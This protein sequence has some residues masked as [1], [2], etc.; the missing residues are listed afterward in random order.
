[1]AYSI[2]EVDGC[3]P[4]QNRF[5]VDIMSSP[6]ELA[7]PE[8]TGQLVDA[9]IPA[10]IMRDDEHQSDPHTMIIDGRD[11]SVDGSKLDTI[12]FNAEVNNLTDQQANSLTSGTHSAWHHHD[13][14]YYRK[15]DLFLPGMSQVNWG[16]LINVPTEFPCAPHDHNDIYYTETEIDNFLA[17]IS[18]SSHDHDDRYYTETEIDTIL[19]NYSLTTHIHDDRYFTETEIET[20]YYDMPEIDALLAGI[21]TQGIKGSVDQHRDLPASGNEEGDI[22]IVRERNGI[23]EPPSYTGA[24]VQNADTALYMKLENTIDDEMGHPN[25]YSGTG[26]VYQA[27]RNGQSGDLNDGFITFTN[28]P[29]FQIVNNFTAGCWLKPNRYDEVMSIFDHWGN[30]SSANGW[31][32]L[33]RDGKIEV[34]LKSTSVPQITVVSYSRIKLDEWTHVAMTYDGTAI[35]LWKN[36]IVV[37]QGIFMG[38]IDNIPNV[39][40]IGRYWTDRIDGEIDELFLE[41][42]TY[43]ELQMQQL[44]NGGLF[45]GYRDE[46]FYRW[47]GSDWIW[48]DFNNGGIYHNSLL[49]LNAEDYRHLDRNEKSDLVDGHDASTRH[50]HGSLYYTQTYVDSNFYTSTQLDGGQLDNRYFTE[51]EIISNYYSSAQLNGGQL[52]NLYYTETEVDN[53]LANK[54]D[55]GHM[56]D[57]RYYTEVEMDITLANYSLI[58]HTHDDRYYQEVEVDNL[59]AGK[60]DVGHIH[61]DRYYTETELSSSSGVSGASLI[62]VSL[63]GGITA[64]NVQDALQELNDDITTAIFTLQEAYESNQTIT[65]NSGPLVLNATSSTDAPMQI[66]N[67]TAAPTS[68]LAGGQMAIINNEFYTFNVDKNKWLTPSKMVFFGKNGSADGHVLRAPGGVRHEESGYKMPKKGTIIAASL[69]ST[70]TTANK[71]VY[72]RINTTNVFTLT[73][74]ASGDDIATT[75]NTDFNIGDVLSAKISSVGNPISNVTVTL[76]IAWRP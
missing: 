59:L 42:S 41:R 17:N 39:I 74:D 11:V 14:W 53:L 54:S 28:S 2:I 48:L 13:D 75:I 1:M 76:E 5:P 9:Q 12:E 33:I 40:D 27:G 23:P 26:M 62:G 10:F 36:A 34:W 63:I 52:N 45:T 70:S 3:P 18:P 69:R 21:E 49:G 68:N 56:H 22:Y 47:D 72:V 44:V 31:A 25:S 7:G 46:G 15:T 50:H 19:N 6:H 61:D 58:T 65:I 67:L 35:K 43:N 57:D 30:G 37:G 4:I 20:N 24:Y 71:N 38:P 16:N 66:T 8:H 51:T 55:I 29:D 73:T 32:L 60:S 64:N